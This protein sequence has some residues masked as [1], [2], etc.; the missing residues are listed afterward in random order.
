MIQAT[1]D[2]V[3]DTDA[4]QQPLYGYD[5]EPPRRRSR[6]LLFIPYF[7]WANRGEGEMRIWIEEA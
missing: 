1:G 6:Q 4:G 3:Q 7:C 5:G 2:S